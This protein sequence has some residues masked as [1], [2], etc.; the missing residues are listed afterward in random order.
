MNN[1]DSERRNINVSSSFPTWRNFTK[2]GAIFATISGLLLFTS[3]CGSSYEDDYYYDEYETVPVT[4]TV[5]EEKPSKGVIMT[6]R[7]KQ[8]GMF[9]VEDEK[10]VDNVSDS[11][12]IVH[13]FDGK[14]SEMT[15]DEA[16]N[17]VRPA[18]TT[19]YYNVNAPSM[20]TL[21]YVLMGSA[22]GYYMGRNMSQPP[23]EHV[24]RQRKD[25]TQSG[26][27]RSSYGGSSGSY[28]SSYYYNN[29]SSLRSTAEQNYTTRTVYRS[30]PSGRSG[31]MGGRSGGRYGGGR[32]SG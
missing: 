17:T 2:K 25:S 7:E 19:M 3:S 32:Y 29:Y 15:M 24:Y 9:E 13:Y 26:G 23:N 20:H 11:R 12:V 10:I 16:K 22:A 18:D 21:G 14:K 4:E 8:A 28:G 27:S 5:L 1:D 6:I 30:V 31:Y